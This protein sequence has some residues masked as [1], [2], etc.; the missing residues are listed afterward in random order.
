QGQRY[1]EILAPALK[2]HHAIG[3]SLRCSLGQWQATR[4]RKDRAEIDRTD[5]HRGAVPRRD[6]LNALCAEK[7]PRRH[8]RYVV[9]DMLCH[10]CLASSCKRSIYW[11][12]K[13][14]SSP[15]RAP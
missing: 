5:S 6:R 3:L 13:I 2:F 10:H 8:E 1:V 4:C 11:R 15:R 9:V 12:P 14:A 7:R